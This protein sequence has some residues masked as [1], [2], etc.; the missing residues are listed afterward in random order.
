MCDTASII[1]PICNTVTIYCK[2][3]TAL[4]GR[5][6]IIGPMCNKATIIGPMSNTATII[7]PSVIQLH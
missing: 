2:C 3:N 6:F 7:G 1:G 5:A 4:I